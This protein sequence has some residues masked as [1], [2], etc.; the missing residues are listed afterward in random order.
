MIAAI[1]KQISNMVKKEK[2]PPTSTDKSLKDAGSSDPK[3]SSAVYTKKDFKRFNCTCTNHLCNSLIVYACRYRTLLREFDDA[4]K[5]ISG[6]LTVLE[7]SSQT[8]LTVDQQ[9]PTTSQSGAKGIAF[10]SSSTAQP[11]DEQTWSRLASTNAGASTGI[12]PRHTNT[13]ETNTVPPSGAQTAN[14]LSFAQQIVIDIGIEIHHQ[15]SPYRHGLFF[16]LEAANLTAGKVSK[17]GKQSPPDV[18]LHTIAQGGHFD[19]VIQDYRPLSKSMNLPVVTAFG[20]RLSLSRLQE[21]LVAAIAKNHSLY[22]AK[23]LGVPRM[24]KDKSSLPTVL[25]VYNEELGRPD[26]LFA[27]DKTKGKDQKFEIVRSRAL[28]KR[29]ISSQILMVV[30][31]LRAIGIKAS[32]CVHQLQASVY[33]NVDH[34]GKRHALGVHTE[35]MTAGDLQRLAHSVGISFIVAIVCE[36]AVQHTIS[37][38]VEPYVRVRFRV[39]VVS[40]LCR[41]YVL[42]AFTLLRYFTFFNRFDKLLP[43][44]LDEM[45]K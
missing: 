5:E 28:S 3:L 43:Q 45:T 40:S 31:T 7:E 16:Q 30:S 35:S 13:S 14:K 26:T 39:Y 4:V 23:Y 2:A 42:I 18:T 32:D 1:Q 10:S 20:M 27:G 15:L 34:L 21:L 41:I 19:Q 25:V 17:R 29:C 24:V 33:R 22:P 6:L 37:R 36:A 38:V 12:A 9:L 11:P 44:F 8:T